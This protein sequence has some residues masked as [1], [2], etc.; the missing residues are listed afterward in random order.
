MP[1]L[2]LMRSRLERR[3]AETRGKLLVAARAL[4][5]E[6]DSLPQASIQEIT[7]LAD[8]GFGSFYNHFDSK[9]DL[10]RAAILDALEE[11]GVIL[12][13]LRQGMDDPAEA[14]AASIRF[15]VRL[16]G[17]DPQLVQVLDRYGLPY[18]SADDGIAGRVRSILAEGGESG[19]FR[20]V[21]PHVGLA[22]TLGSVLTLIHLS[23]AAPE[24]VGDDAWDELAERLLLMLGL[25]PDEAHTI[26]T[27]PLPDL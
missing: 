18:L 17:A 21:D 13:R 22:A 15:G 10:F 26:A 19:R 4:L 23:L 2:W 27:K 24:A 16:V 6:T 1:I 12:D 11:V 9:A 7:E 3:K 14:F 25:E 5:A 8:V 20:T